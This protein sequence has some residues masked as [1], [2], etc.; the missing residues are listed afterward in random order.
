M[1]R[2]VISPEELAEYAA[3]LESIEAEGLFKV[4]RPLRSPQGARVAVDGRELLNLCT[5]DYLGL[6]ANPEVIASA[7]AALDRDGFGMAS[8]RFISGTHVDH[9]E[10]EAELTAWL[11][12]DDTILFP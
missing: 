3:T 6:A 11:G 5:N 9:K 2:G 1:G 8:V 12:T 10:L 7:H 4:E